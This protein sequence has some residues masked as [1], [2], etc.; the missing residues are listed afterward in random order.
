[1]DNCLKIWDFSAADLQQAIVQSERHGDA[2]QE[3]ANKSF[4]TVVVHFP[5]FS[6]AVVHRNYVDC[7]MWLGDMIF[8]KSTENKIICWQPGG[9]H[10]VDVNERIANELGDPATILHR[11]ASSC[12]DCVSLENLN[13]SL[14]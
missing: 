13:L 12:C 8:S 7:A 3:A 6:T 5:V 14:F 4:P 10:R 2:D 1:M 9:E 11:S